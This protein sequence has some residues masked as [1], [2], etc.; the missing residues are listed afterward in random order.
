M[1]SENYHELNNQRI[2]ERLEAGL[3]LLREHYTVEECE[4]D[5]A[6]ANPNVGGRPNHVRRFDVKGVGNLLMMT[7]KDVES[8]QLSS[9]VLMPYF[10]NLPLFSTDYVYNDDKR[11]FLIEIYDLSVAHDAA[12]DAGIQALEDLAASWDDMPP[13]PTQPRW[14]D[15]IRPVCIA[16]APSVEQDGLSLERFLAALDAFVQME[17]AAPALSDADRARKWQKN[18][19]YSDGLVDRGGVSTDLWTDALGAENVRRFFDEVFFG[20]ACYKKAY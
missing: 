17:K 12:F 15:D 18:K 6:F 4:I 5:P 10:K 9:F 16:K 14:Y 2:D 8:N 13:F 20:P 11:F 19:D 1:P 7:A 3:A